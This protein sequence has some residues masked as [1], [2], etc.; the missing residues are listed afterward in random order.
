MAIGEEAERRIS[1]EKV[2][3]DALGYVRRQW[4]AMLLF[5]AAAWGLTLLSIK[6]GGIE[7]YG[8]WPVLVA[9]YLLESV[10]FRFY[11]AKRPYLQWRPIAVSLIPSVKVMFLAAVFAVLLSLLPFVP[12]LLGIPYFEE[13]MNSLAYADDYLSFLQRYMQDVPLVDVG[14]ERGFDFG[15]AVYFVS[16]DAGLDCRG[17]GAARIFAFGMA[18]KQRKLSAVCLAGGGVVDSADDLVSYRYVGSGGSLL[19]RSF[20]GS[21]D[22]VFECGFGR[23]L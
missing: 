19:Y 23:D 13:Y 6:A 15:F 11:F 12:L 7:G 21:A 18:Q 5:T 3:R 4:K 9:L 22:D 1:A 10:F 2:L 20:I 17:Y 8:F 16:A 14:S